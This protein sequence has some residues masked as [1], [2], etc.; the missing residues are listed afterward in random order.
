MGKL[1]TKVE[2]NLSRLRIQV[3][4]LLYLS[5][6]AFLGSPAW[7]QLLCMR[8]GRQQLHRVVLWLLVWDLTIALVDSNLNSIGGTSLLFFSPHLN[9]LRKIRADEVN[10]QAFS[11]L[12]GVK[13]SSRTA[14]SPVRCV[15][16]GRLFS[17]SGM[18]SRMTVFPVWCVQ[19][20]P[21]HM[22]LDC[23]FLFKIFLKSSF[24]VKSNQQLFPFQAT[25]VLP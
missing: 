5:R 2:N 8:S 6:S 15:Q 12:A 17:W 22:C 3:P 7:Q 19:V 24:L 10:G 4:F 14:V 23:C 20:W 16:V 9:Q 18:C 25:G 11:H 21:L 13:S 1:W